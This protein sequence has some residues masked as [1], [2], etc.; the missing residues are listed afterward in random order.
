MT[1]GLEIEGDRLSRDLG[2]AIRG[3]RQSSGT[4][5]RSLAARAGLS[6]PFLSA[7]ERGLSMPSIVT[8]YRL[9]EALDVPPASLLPAETGGDVQVI[10]GDEGR[11]VPSSERPGSAVGRLLLSDEDHG[12][13]VYEYHV[14]PDE[15]LDVWFAHDGRKVLHLIGG[16]LRVDLEGRTPV[17][18]GAGDCL[19]HDARIAHRWTV[20]GEDPV[21]LFLVV[22]HDGG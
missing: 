22:Q 19:V 17:R 3:A 10:R 8:L 12:L 4:S 7:V 20:E 15:D 2:R 1:T 5:M 11:L 13:E 21:R 9:A 16:V 18:L 6:Q 14:G